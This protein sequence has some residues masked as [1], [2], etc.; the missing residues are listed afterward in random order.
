MHLSYI[1]YQEKVKN[2]LK[3]LAIMKTIL[4]FQHIEMDVLKGII[5]KLKMR[6]V[7]AIQI[8]NHVLSE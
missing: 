4:A 2:A 6:Q 5:Q 7:N 8:P 3:D 1:I